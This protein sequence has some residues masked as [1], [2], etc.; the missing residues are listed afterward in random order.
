MEQGGTIQ[1]GPHNIKVIENVCE[2]SEYVSKYVK[3]MWQ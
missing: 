1:N 3:S 2:L